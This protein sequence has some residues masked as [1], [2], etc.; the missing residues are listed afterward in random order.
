MALFILI[1]KNVKLKLRHPLALTMEILIPTLFVLI[2]SYIKTKVSYVY[3][4]N[5][6]F[7]YSFTQFIKQVD[8]IQ[9][10]PL[11]LSPMVS[12]SDRNAGN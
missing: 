2:F 4:L 10:P 11:H 9:V 7:Y 1:W 8:P 6:F 12:T 3:F 5:H